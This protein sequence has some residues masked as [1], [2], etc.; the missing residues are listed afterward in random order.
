MFKL[1]SVVHLRDL[2]NISIIGDNN[3]TVSCDNAGGIHFEHCCNC[4][5]TGI[6]LEN[7]GIYIQ[8]TIA[9]QQ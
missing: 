9:S 7:C 4:T 2:Q 3:Q 5:A 8:Q 1:L 6:I